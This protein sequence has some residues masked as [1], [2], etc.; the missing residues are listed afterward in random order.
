V[1][2]GLTFRHDT[3]TPGIKF[4]DKALD[5]RI[6]ELAKYHAQRAE[7][8]MK[9]NAPWTDQTGNARNGLAAEA[10]HKP[11]KEHVIVL[12]HQVPYGIWLEV[13][14]EGRFAIVIPTLKK[15]AREVMEDLRKL[16]RSVRKS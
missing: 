3:L 10:F 15:T 12:A 5:E 2:S 6:G 1:P 8:Y 14:H 11:M 4:F 9:Q 16:F 7:D 13:R